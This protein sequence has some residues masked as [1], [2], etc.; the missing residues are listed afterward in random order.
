M[1]SLLAI[2]IAWRPVRSWIRTD[3]AVAIEE[4]RRRGRIAQ[5]AE[6]LRLAVPNALVDQ[7]GRVGLPGRL[8]GAPSP[9]RAER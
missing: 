5:S 1:L 6:V 2:A 7:V 3:L 4:Y 9:T 8:I